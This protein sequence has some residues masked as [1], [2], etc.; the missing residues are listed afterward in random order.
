[1]RCEYASEIAW[2]ECYLPPCSIHFGIFF[3]SL[4]KR[5]VPGHSGNQRSGRSSKWAV[6]HRDSNHHSG[7]YQRQPPDFHKALCK[8]FWN[9]VLI[10]QDGDIIKKKH[11]I[12][13][14][15][16]MSRFKFSTLVLLVSSQCKRKWEGQSHP[17]Y[18]CWRQGFGQHAKLDFKIC[19]Q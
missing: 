15:K 17:P 2:W 19:H 4:D 18:S 16:S 7:R 11:L 14:K 5:Q 9:N 1:M 8:W 12:Y 6:Q 10:L 3:C 13:R